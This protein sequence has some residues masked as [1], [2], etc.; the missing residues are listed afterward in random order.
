MNSPSKP[1]HDLTALETRCLLLAACG[2][3]RTDIVME[4][5]LPQDRVDMAFEQAME[6]LQ[7]KNLAEAIFRAARMKLI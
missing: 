1:G 7:A 2:R 4:T 5:D 3:S 6:K